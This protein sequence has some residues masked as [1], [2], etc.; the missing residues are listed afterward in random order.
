VQRVGTSDDPFVHLEPLLSEFAG[1]VQ[2]APARA[3]S[4]RKSGRVTW[5]FATTRCHHTP[6]ERAAGLSP[7]ETRAVKV[8][9]YEARKRWWEVV[10]RGG[11]EPPTYRFSATSPTVQTASAVAPVLVTAPAATS[12]TR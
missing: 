3:A 10:A 6:H 9:H 11:V 1:S 5:A 2:G 7:T 4:R 12:E 8:D